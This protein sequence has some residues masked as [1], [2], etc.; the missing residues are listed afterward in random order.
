MS[1]PIC[2]RVTED[3]RE[4]LSTRED[5]P[6]LSSSSSGE[7]IKEKSE[8]CKKFME[9]GY[10][11]YGDKCKFAHGSHQLKQNNGENA[12]YKTKE[13]FTFF[14]GGHC[15]YGDRCNFVHQPSP[16]SASF[17][18]ALNEYPHLL[19]GDWT[20]SGSSKLAHLSHI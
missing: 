7:W 16:F 4:S 10:C 8:L 19:H 5:S 20:K 14:N 13:C 9:R 17:S 3:E 12:K 11:P 18:S 2:K 1:L 6:N 15:K